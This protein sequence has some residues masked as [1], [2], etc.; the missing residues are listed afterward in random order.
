M[1]LQQDDVHIVDAP[2][3]WTSPETDLWVASRSGEYAGMIEF[4]D[5][6]FIAL[7]SMGT[8]LGMFSSIPTARSAVEVGG[9]ASP[10]V[11][12]APRPPRASG[13]NRVL[14]SR[15]GGPTL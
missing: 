8:E 5:G 12:R 7:D 15:Q 10:G 11:A 2:I 1:T 3:S 14:R 9:T 4:R 6:H 13:I